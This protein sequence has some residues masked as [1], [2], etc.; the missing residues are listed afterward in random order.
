MR[1]L[2]VLAGGAIGSL[3]RWS[4]G[5]LIEAESGAFP[6]ATLAVNVTG[7]FLLGAAGALLIERVA[8][9][10]LMRTFFL[11]GLLGAYTT[12][13]AMAMEGVLLIEGGRIAAAMTYWVATLLLG[14]T[15]AFSGVRL[16]RVGT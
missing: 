12:F 13:S 2:S 16:G 8:G 5:E 1:S 7:A 11:I 6:W 3:A 9:A 15:A 14:Q 10:G 4:V